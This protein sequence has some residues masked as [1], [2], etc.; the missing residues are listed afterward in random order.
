MLV[1]RVVVTQIGTMYRHRERLF[2]RELGQHL[3]FV[4]FERMSLCRSDV[5]D[6][7]SLSNFEA[8]CVIVGQ[9]DEVPTC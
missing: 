6:A 2:Q 3:L 5:I 1:Y 8:L 9:W 4:D 7:S